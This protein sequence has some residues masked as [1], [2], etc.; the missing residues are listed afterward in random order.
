MK[1]R[2]AMWALMGFIVACGWALFAMASGPEQFL[3]TLRTPAVSAALYVSCP[4]LAMLRHN[5]LHLWLALV[6]NTATYLVVGTA[7]ESVRFRRK[8]HPVL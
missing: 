8:S 4:L 6:I 3:S 2:I 7:V 1:H 5:Q